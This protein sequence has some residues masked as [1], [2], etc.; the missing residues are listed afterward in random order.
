MRTVDS[1]GGRKAPDS[2]ERGNGQVRSGWSHCLR[3]QLVTM[4]SLSCLICKMEPLLGHLGGSV[5]GASH[6]WGR[7]SSGAHSSVSS[8]R[9]SG[10]GRDPAWDSLPLP[11]PCLSPKKWSSCYPPTPYPRRTRSCDTDT[12]TAG[13]QLSRVPVSGCPGGMA[14]HL[15]DIVAGRRTGASIHTVSRALP[16]PRPSPAPRG[17][18]LCRG[19]RQRANIY[20]GVPWLEGPHIPPLYLRHGY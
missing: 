1:R 2:S 16:G 19:E 17:L 20:K 3:P 14:G 13:L 6:P 12:R 7:L 4:L 9:A 5:D 10:C 8:S 11:L 15:P 18:P